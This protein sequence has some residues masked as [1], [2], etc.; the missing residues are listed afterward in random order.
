M[1]ATPYGAGKLLWEV[2]TSVLCKQFGVSDKAL[3][4]WAKAYDL[5]KP[6]RGFWQRKRSLVP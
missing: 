2:P 6:P 3:E 5:S 1:N 4:K